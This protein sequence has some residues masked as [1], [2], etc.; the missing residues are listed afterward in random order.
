MVIKLYQLQSIAANALLGNPTGSASEVQSLLLDTSLFFNNSK[1][2]AALTNTYIGV[3][4]GSNQ[5]SGSSDLTFDGSELKVS[6]SSGLPSVRVERGGSIVGWLSIPSTNYSFTNTDFK[7]MA[8]LFGSAPGIGLVS[9]D[10]GIKVKN[11]G[12]GGIEFWAGYGE[13]LRL[14]NSGVIFPG[15]ATWGN[16]QMLTV[17]YGGNVDKAPIIPTA[18]NSYSPTITND[19]NTG[20]LSVSNAVYTRVDNI[21]DVSVRGQFDVSGASPSFKLSLPVNKSFTNK[22]DVIGQGVIFDLSNQSTAVTVGGGSNTAI[23]EVL[24]DLAGTATNSGTTYYFS[25]NFKYKL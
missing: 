3:G 4:D 2:A 18:G 13:K 21:V 16:P 10:N 15:L 8:V 23:I 25:I 6:K 11:T 12:V 7:D 1:L 17:G 20:S 9:G 5:L 22:Y 19:N 24:T 14:T